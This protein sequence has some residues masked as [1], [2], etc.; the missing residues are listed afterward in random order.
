MAP[1]FGACEDLGKNLA[2]NATQRGKELDDVLDGER[3]ASV[4]S[5]RGA[6]K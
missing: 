6:E 5:R 2:A 4:R 3:R 1:Y